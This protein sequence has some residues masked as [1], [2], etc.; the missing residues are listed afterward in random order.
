M[1]QLHAQ[2]T[3]E[4]AYERFLNTCP[5]YRSTALL[6]EVRAFDFARL[7]EQRLVT[8]STRIV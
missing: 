3:S 4:T 8:S 2:D 1:V 5:A 6:D 7:D